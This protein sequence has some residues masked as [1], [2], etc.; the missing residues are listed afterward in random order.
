MKNPL[1]CSLFLTTCLVG[2]APII[3]AVQAEQPILL[4]QSVWKP[5]ASRAGGFTVLMPSTPNQSQQTLQTKGGP[6]KVQLFQAFRPNQAGYVV[7]YS[8]LPANL[9]KTQRDV[10]DFLAGAIY[11]FT[12]SSKGKLLSQRNITL[13]NSPGREFKVQLSQ[14]VII[15]SR[16]YLVDRRRF[17]QVFVVT[18]R[19]QDLVKSIDGFLTSFKLIKNPSAARKVPKENLNASLQKAVCAQNWTQA[20]KVIDR[21]RKVVRDPNTQSQLVAYRQQLQGLANSDV[22]VPASV[23][24]GCTAAQSAK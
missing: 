2:G 21:M 8:E 16:F 12:N 13:A 17:Y 11:G 14:G 22:P 19:E 1:L 3:N 7:G 18:D 24:T 15:K 23:L 10:N 6:I 4:A 5:F 20:I 9:I